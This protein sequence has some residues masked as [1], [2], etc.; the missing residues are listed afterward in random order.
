MRQRQRRQKKKQRGKLLVGGG[1]KQRV[2][3]TFALLLFPLLGKL[4]LLRD[5]EERRKLEDEGEG[6]TKRKDG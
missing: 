6:R 2:F 5:E 3:E 1:E 4:Q